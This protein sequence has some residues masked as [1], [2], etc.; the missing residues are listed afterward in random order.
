MAMV[1]SFFVAWGVARVLANVTLADRRG[2]DAFHQW[3]VALTSNQG[4]D[5]AAGSV[6]AAGAVH[7]TVGV[8]WALLY[9][10]YFEPRLA[11]PGWVR[12]LV[13]ALIPWALS[14]IVFLP[15]VGGGLL[16]F[17]LGAGPLP[18][19]GNF[20]LHAVYGSTLGAMYGPLGD[21]AADEFPH[22]GVTDDP[23]VVAQYELAAARGVILGAIMGLVVGAALAVLA[24]GQAAAAPFGVPP[25]AFPPVMAVIGASFGGLIGSLSGMAA[26]AGGG[27]EADRASQPVDR[28]A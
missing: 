10:Y 3:M 2:A 16:G 8:L 9:G 25:L 6:Y 24:A 19:I 7:L 1:I 4:L 26:A 11:G 15:L 21:I 12:G 5:L 17:A 18:I 27:N 13:F 14:I 22:A 28:P 23:A 20:V